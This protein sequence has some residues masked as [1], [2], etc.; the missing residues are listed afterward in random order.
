MA[1]KQEKINSGMH[2]I[3]LPTAALMVREIGVKMNEPI[4]FWGQPG[5]GKTDLMNQINKQCG[6]TL[7]DV[8]L[9]QYESV[10]LRG[11][12]VPDP[13]QDQTVWYAPITLPFKGNPNFVEDKKPIFLFLDEFN[14][15]HQSVFGVA[16]Q[17]INERRIGEHTLM[18]NVVIVAA[19]NREHDR[20][21][22]NRMPTT[23]ANRLTHAEIG[24]DVDAWCYWA[25]DAGLPAVGIAYIQFQKQHLSNFDPLSPAKAF[26]TPRTWEKALRYYAAPIPEDVKQAAIAGVIGE[27]MAAEFWGF[28][29][30]WQSIPKMSEIEKSPTTVPV[31]EEASMRYAT[32]VAVS[33][34]ITPKNA[35]PFHTYLNRMDPEFVILAWQLALRRDP[36]VS[37]TK[38]FID[39]AK[40]HRAIFAR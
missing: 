19:G 34:A 3:N 11:I 6:G 27:G 4:M 36:Q 39:M 15:C 28:V 7:C 10:D 30:V 14:Q 20:G 31:P 16:M 9:G 5:I 22:T 2:T 21:V 26:A 33:G 35:T 18:D 17:L 23:I 29:D 13:K 38:E 24:I 25:Q 32:A 1:K 37:A 12:P 40:K 8:R